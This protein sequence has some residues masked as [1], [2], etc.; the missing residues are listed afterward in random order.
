M[1]WILPINVAESASLLIYQVKLLISGKGLT[2]TPGH[3]IYE[4][5]SL[6]STWSKNDMEL[7]IT[8]SL[9]YFSW[10]RLEDVCALRESTQGEVRKRIIDGRNSHEAAGHGMLST[11]DKISL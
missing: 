1:H 7:T 5:S 9:F 4:L 8:A 11:S 6:P 2:D 3:N 10:K